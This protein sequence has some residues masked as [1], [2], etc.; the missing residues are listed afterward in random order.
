MCKWW[1]NRNLCASYRMRPSRP[2]RAPNRG[3]ANR[4][5]Q[6]EHIVCGRR[7]AWSPLHW[8]PCKLHLWI[9]GLAIYVGSHLWIWLKRLPFKT[10][11]SIPI[12]AEPITWSQSISRPVRFLFR[13]QGAKVS[14]RLHNRKWR[15][16]TSFQNCKIIRN[17]LNHFREIAIRI[18]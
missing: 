11:S 10:N 12:I 2:L 8:W 18:W 1:A 4:R 5:R 7:A 3:V 9:S 16:W 15:T 6:T 14:N 17:R 13:G